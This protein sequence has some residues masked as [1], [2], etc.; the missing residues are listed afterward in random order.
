MRNNSQKEKTI[1]F[2]VTEEE[3]DAWGKA[4]VEQGYSSRSQM[5][6]RC[7]N[8][9]IS[10]GTHNCSPWA[11]EENVRLERTASSLIVIEAMLSADN[12]NIR[13]NPTL[14]ESLQAAID[15]V[16]SLKKAG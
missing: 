6:R 12:D 14:I 11:M 7:V 8:S 2:R 13:D 3:F 10:H 1:S 16:L 9:S 15:H 4:W 5:I